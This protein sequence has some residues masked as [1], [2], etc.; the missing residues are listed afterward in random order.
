MIF[1]FLIFVKIQQIH[2]LLLL[3]YYEAAYTTPM[4]VIAT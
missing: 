3:P 2:A 4:P 1:G